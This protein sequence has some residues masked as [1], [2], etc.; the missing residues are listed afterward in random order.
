MEKANYSKKNETPELGTL[1]LGNASVTIEVDYKFKSSI[2]VDYLTFTFPFDYI[3]HISNFENTKEEVK[4]RF[5][6][7]LN[8]LK[9]DFKS[10]EPAKCGTKGFMYGMTW[11][12]PIQYVGDK[13]P[14]TRFDYWL[15]FN[16]LKIGCFELSGGCCRD[17]ERRCSAEELNV[18]SS[19]RNLLDNIYFK[20]HG[21]AS[22][23]DIAFDFYNI[24]LEDPFM[25]FYNKILNCEFSSP[26]RSFSPSITFKDDG[27]SRSYKAQIFHIGEMTGSVSAV[28]YNKKLE[29]AH[30]NNFVECK[31]WLRFEIRFKDEKADNLVS[32]LLKNWESKDIYLVGILK[33]YFDFK[34]RPKKNKDVF[35]KRNT[36]YNWTTD[37]IWEEMTNS[38]FKQTLVN[39]FERESSIKG[40]AHY[41]TNYQ[42]KVLTSLYLANGP[43]G[44]K[45]ILKNALAIGCSDLDNNDFSRI[46]YHRDKLSMNA[47]TLQDVDALIDDLN[48]ELEDEAYDPVV[49]N[50]EGEVVVKKEDFLFGLEAK[51]QQIYPAEEFKKYE[52]KKNLNSLIS[53]M[54]DYFKTEYDNFTEDEVL[55][56]IASV[57]KGQKKGG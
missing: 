18:D 13:N 39:Q 34:I 24:D 23:I 10:G 26:I 51:R 48:K 11:A 9:L 12:V 49:I 31:N 37:P 29:Q 16:N 55:K 41:L 28:F 1:A 30:Q 42:K 21:S 22:R 2:C 45:Q 38:V 25:Y 46:N 4:V 47:I 50:D 27:D 6:E 43:V 35:V 54:K 52:K 33:K 5:Y 36:R 19:W 44:F 15:R 3:E 20:Y 14:S 40:K 53:I 17:F 8:D 56:F 7:I 57:V 32:G